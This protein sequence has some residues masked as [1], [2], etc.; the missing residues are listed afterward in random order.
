MAKLQVMLKY[1][2]TI[3]T[4]IILTIISGCVLNN[5]DIE[6]PDYRV[7]Q[8]KGPIEHRVYQPAI[9]AQVVV[10]GEREEALN[11][12]FKLIAGPVS[13]IG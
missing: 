12:G 1:L 13:R 9:V 8:Q 6:N 2:K 11:E 7:T 4:L 3:F 10:S 5:S